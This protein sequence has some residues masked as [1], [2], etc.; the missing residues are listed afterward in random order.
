MTRPGQGCR[1]AVNGRLFCFTSPPWGCA[2]IISLF[3]SGRLD[4]DKI[5]RGFLFMSCTKQTIIDSI[6][7]K[8][9]ISAQE[10]RKV[11]EDLLEIMKST[12][13]SGE[14]VMC[15]GFGTFC[16][17][18]KS[19]RKGRNPAT[20][21]AMTLAGRRVVTFKCSGKLRDKINNGGKFSA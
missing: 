1:P 8:M 7:E 16:V 20:G 3:E 18:G 14:N 12:L 2:G 17:K 15:S 9:Q 21:D 11:V 4:C 6:S 13:V 19:P 5:I 10:S